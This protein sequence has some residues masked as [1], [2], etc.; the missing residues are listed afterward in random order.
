MSD[1]F[2]NILEHT[3]H[4]SKHLDTVFERLELLHFFKEAVQNMNPE[5]SKEA[6]REFYSYIK[7][8]HENYVPPE[9]LLAAAIGRTQFFHGVVYTT[10]LDRLAPSVF[11]YSLS[12]VHIEMINKMKDPAGALGMTYA[13]IDTYC[14]YV[15]SMESIQIT[16]FSTKVLAL[17]DLNMKQ[18]LST[19]VL[20]EH[21]HLHP[22][23]LQKKFKQE[24]GRNITDVIGERRV[25]LA[26]IYLRSSKLS[27]T[28]VAYEVGFSDASY[29]GKVFRKFVGMTPSQFRK[30]KERG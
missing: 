16:D 15:N 12:L 23:Y 18:E 11:A 26:K 13:M 19:S 14:E 8:D 7:H 28:D 17:I 10:L 4:D 27:V 5:K 30:E 21:L 3:I 24:T 20:A 29:F 25:E 1:K 9:N 2:E 6:I 22:D